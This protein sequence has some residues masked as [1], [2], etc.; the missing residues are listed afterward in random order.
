MGT[1]LRLGPSNREIALSVS[2]WGQ[3]LQPPLLD[4]NLGWGVW[5]PPK[6]SQGSCARRRESLWKP[7]RQGPQTGAL[8]SLP[9][10]SAPLKTGNPPTPAGV[11][12]KTRHG[13][14]DGPCLTPAGLCSPGGES[15]RWRVWLHSL[16]TTPGVRPQPRDPPGATQL[17]GPQRRPGP[18]VL[19]ETC[20][21]AVEDTVP[22]GLGRQRGPAQVRMPYL[23]QQPE[24]E[25]ESGVHPGRGGS[26]AGVHPRPEGAS[27]G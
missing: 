11:P 26:G 7:G 20:A 14:L 6:T 4:G 21:A 8:L 5:T 18:V 12:P 16:P 3:G 1:W 10:L 23:G 27:P 24:D 22:Q 17:T 19:G 2:S 25:E 15:T 13:L 9:P